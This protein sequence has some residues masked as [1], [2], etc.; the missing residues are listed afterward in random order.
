MFSISI[1]ISFTCLPILWQLLTYVPLPQN[2]IHTIFFYSFIHSFNRVGG[3]CVWGI[4][5]GPR[6]MMVTKARHVL[7]TWSLKSNWENRHRQEN[8]QVDTSYSWVRCRKPTEVCVE[9]G[10]GGQMAENKACLVNSDVLPTPKR[11]TQNLPRKTVQWMFAD[12]QMMTQHQKSTWKFSLMFGR[13]VSLWR[14]D[15]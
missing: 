14:E 10:L 9:N 13:V 8:K 7:S 15:S 2:T 6:D 1:C 5:L 3:V 11:F 4:M 12:W